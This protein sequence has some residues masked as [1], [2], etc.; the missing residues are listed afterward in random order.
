[1]ITSRWIPREALFVAALDGTLEV[2]LTRANAS[3][4]FED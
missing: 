3:R 4:P 2:L 1:M